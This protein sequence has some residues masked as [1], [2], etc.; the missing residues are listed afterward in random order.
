MKDKTL[1]EALTIACLPIVIPLVL[2]MASCD[3]QIPESPESS[4]VKHIMQKVDHVDGG[5]GEPDYW[6]LRDSRTGVE[7]LVV[8]HGARHVSVTPMRSLPFAEKK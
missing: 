5:M 7:Y 3:P 1:S 6:V 2:I 8:T 4:G